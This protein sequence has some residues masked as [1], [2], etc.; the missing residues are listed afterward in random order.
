LHGPEAG[1]DWTALAALGAVEKV[2][3]GNFIAGF[4]TPA[5]VFGADFVLEAGGVSREDLD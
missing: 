1:V 3:A 4:Q 2:L 5:Q